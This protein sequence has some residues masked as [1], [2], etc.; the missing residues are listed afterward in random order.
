LQIKH[1]FSHTNKI[2]NLSLVNKV[3]KQWIIIYKYESIN[4]IEYY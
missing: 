4:V 3:W 2:E 1:F